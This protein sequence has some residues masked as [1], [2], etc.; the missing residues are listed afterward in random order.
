M[1]EAFGYVGVP[2]WW[3]VTSTIMHV[4]VILAF[5]AMAFAM[6]KLVGIVNEL[7]TKVSNTVDTME[8][9]AK[10]F[11][12]H[13]DV[14]TD[15]LMAR[16]EG[17][18]DKLDEIAAT[19]KGTVEDVSGRTRGLASRMEGVANTALVKFDKASP[20]IGTIVAGMKLYNMFI[21]MRAERASVKSEVDMNGR[22][23]DNLPVRR[24]VEQSGSSSG[25]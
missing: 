10:G 22:V 3:L 9:K 2:T 23:R 19:A 8:A 15:A 24:G 14:K 17:V 21:A 18:T 4:V 1:T 13:V 6:F 12:D 11:I 5:G 25:S 16:I 20:L 7:K